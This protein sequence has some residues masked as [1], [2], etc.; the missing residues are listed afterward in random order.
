MFLYYVIIKF[1]LI[2]NVAFL[3]Y[4]THVIDKQKLFENSYLW[5]DRLHNAYDNVTINFSG[6]VFFLL[7]RGHAHNGEDV[8]EYTEDGLSLIAALTIGREWNYFLKN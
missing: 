2:N 6:F 4:W 5:I 1:V 3:L 8:A 7:Q